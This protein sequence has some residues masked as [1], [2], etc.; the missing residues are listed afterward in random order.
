M[1]LQIVSSQY[2]HLPGRGEDTIAPHIIKAASMMKNEP[3]SFQALY[4]GTAGSNFIP[5]RFYF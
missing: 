2:K 4:L 5:V 1:N 3:F